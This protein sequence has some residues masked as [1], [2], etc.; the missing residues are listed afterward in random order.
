LDNK[1]GEKI[2]EA[3]TVTAFDKEI[4]LETFD[5]T[6]AIKAAGPAQSPDRRYYGFTLSAECI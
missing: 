2:E 5:G 3:G 1:G 6:H 4:D